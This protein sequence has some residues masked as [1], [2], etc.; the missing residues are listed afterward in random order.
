MADEKKLFDYLKRVTADLQQTRSRLREVEEKDREPIAIVAMSCRYPGDVR[1][2]EDLWELVASGTDAIS[3]FPADRGWDTEGLYDPDP[4]RPGSVYVREGG[5]LHDAAHFDAGFFGISPHEASAMDPQQ[6]LL[7]ETSWEAFERAG[8]DPASAKG[9]PTGVFTGVMYDDYAKRL[10][11]V[12]ESVEGQL[13][14]GSAPSVASGRVAYMFGLEGPA[15]TLDTACSS[16][17]VALHLACHALRSGEC[18]LALAGGATVMAA[19]DVFVEFSRQRGLAPDGRCKS[20]AAGADGTAWSEGVGVLLVE[21]L[22]DAR[23]R[24]HPVLAVIRGSAVNQ[25]GA[26]NGLTA[27]NG[28]S[29]ERVIRQALAGAGLVPADVDAVEAHGTGTRLGDPIEAQALLATYGRDRSADRP[30][31]LGSLKSNIGH[32]QAAAGVGGVIKMVQAM[33][34]GLLPQTL[35]VQEPTPHVDW[36]KGAVSLLNEPASWP[37]TGH[38]RRAGVSSFGVSGTNAHLI[39]E[40]VPQAEAAADVSTADGEAPADPTAP[41]TFPW[42]VSGRTEAALRDQAARLRA[43]AAADPG[44]RRVDVGFS[45]A[46][47]RATFEHRAVVVS[48]GQDGFL[49]GLDAIARGGEAPGL[50][51][52]AADTAGKV[53]F[54]FPGQ[55]AQWEGMAADL[56]ESSPVFAESIRECERAL[57]AY[58]D[59][60][61]L[62]L[63]RGEADAPSADRVDVVQPALW[64]VMV[65]LARL[66]RSHGVEPAAV[67]GHS[68]GEIAAACVAGA[69]SVD[70]GARVVALRSQAVAASLAGRGG[71]VSLALPVDRVES[72]L[73]RWPGRISVA[74]VNGPGSVVVA[75]EPEALDELCGA[76]EAEGVRA[77][78]IPVDYASHSAQVEALKDRLLDALSGIAPRSAEIPFLSTVTGGWLDTAQLD[79]DYWYR[80]LR[81]R[82]RFEQAVRTL[83]GQGHGFFLEASPH[84]VLTIGIEETVG[85]LDADAVAVGTLHRGEGGLD[86]FLLS[87][88]EAHVRGLAVDWGQA[89][90]GHQ[91]HVVDLPTYAFQHQ[92]YWLEAGEPSAAVADTAETSFWEAVEQGDVDVVADS[93]DVGDGER[94]SLEAVLPALSSWRRRSRERSIVDGWRYK[95]TWK[96]EADAAPPTLDGTWLVVVPAAH[97]DE[98]RVAAVIGALQRHGAQAVRIELDA[99]EP[100]REWIAQRIRNGGTPVAG[101]LSLLGLDERPYPDHPAVP[102]GV[103]ATLALVQAVGDADARLWL[104]TCGAVSTGRSDRLTSRSRP[105]CG[106]WA[107]SS[108]WS[109]PNAGADW[110]T[111]PSRR[112]S[113]RWTGWPECSPGRRART[114]SR[115]GPPGCSCSGWF[116][117]RVRTRPGR[118]GSRAGPCW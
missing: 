16:S 77:R 61:L 68:Q 14:L 25:D 8:I 45:L 74:V 28:P 84:P 75:G 11:R 87:M 10:H 71:M 30:L 107:G 43:A 105:W 36:D 99:A 93:L 23:R 4:D 73:E 111:F 112:V 67:V 7:L 37:E 72:L 62:D 19:P 115:C 60:S 76:C 41:P 9:S 42:V 101:V 47:T 89:F 100:D 92:R 50:V 2:P 91:A 12:P 18:S 52:G 34:H 66:W 39:V 98:D 102:A 57:A 3:A 63:L 17:L 97:T 53:T 21:R 27:P 44:P 86:R 96:P 29:Q 40:Q 79:A 70:D 94:S 22:S 88:A 20:F 104:A 65:S 83:V 54:V 58:V 80:N 38:P 114:R 106:G 49:D 48:G 33:R 5:F 46:T 1:S 95:V 35:H 103:A 59:W 116:V 85:A 55:G 118:R 6:R 31:R 69:L 90:A 109:T 13:L 108:R 24:G 51:Q 15:V 113:G 64:A 26:S 110:S 78:R 82:V 32:T 117:L 56:L 81:Q